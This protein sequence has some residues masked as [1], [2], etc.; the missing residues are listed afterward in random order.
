MKKAELTTQQIVILIVLITSFAIV[1]FLLFRLNLGETSNKE[2]CH[3]SVVL[4]GQSALKSGALDCKT[5]YVCI[6]AGGECT[7]ITADSVVEVDLNKD[8]I[9]ETIAEEMVDCW[10]MFGEGKVDY[11][12]KFAYSG[13]HCA[14]CSIIKF[15]DKIQE[16]FEEITYQELY[17]FLNKNKKSNTQTYLN[18]LYEIELSELKDK[19]KKLDISNE[20]IFTNEKYAIITGMNKNAKIWILGWDDNIVYPYFVKSDEIKDKTKCNVFDITKA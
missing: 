3:N 16:K 9:L 1:L 15:D 18:Y 8:E 7:D 10:W 20:K 4:K 11:L 13:Y 12:D 14:M 2:I 19:N 6:S 17:D 5:N